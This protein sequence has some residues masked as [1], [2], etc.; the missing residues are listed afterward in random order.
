M[1]CPCIHIW[2]REVFF[3]PMSS[4]IGRPEGMVPLHILTSGNKLYEIQRSGSRSGRTNVADQTWSYVNKSGGRHG[5]FPQQ[6]STPCGAIWRFGPRIITRV[7][8]FIAH[9]N[10]THACRAE[11]L[12][13]NCKP[14][15]RPTERQSTVPRRFEYFRPRGTGSHDAGF[16]AKPP[17]E[18]SLLIVM[19][20]D[21]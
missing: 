15:R 21:V 8:P 18:I 1:L 3:L 20:A 19:C 16:T 2:P 17:G 14:H 6:R 4:S 9:S 13:G 10:D 5:D 11:L 7:N 12:A